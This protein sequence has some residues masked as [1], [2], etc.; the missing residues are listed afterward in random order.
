MNINT[1]FISKGFVKVPTVKVV[2]D[3]N[4]M[5]ENASYEQIFNDDAHYALMIQTELMRFGYILSPDAFNGVKLLMKQDQAQLATD[6]ANYFKNLYGDGQYTTLFGDYPNT[7]LSMEESEWMAKQILHYWTA[8]FK[9]FG[10]FDEDQHYNPN[11][12]DPNDSEHTGLSSM[13]VCCRDEYKVINAGSAD[14]LAEIIKV[15]V[16]SQQSLTDFDKDVV[17]TF[18]ENIDTIGLSPMKRVEMLDIN[19]PFKETLC[20]VS[21][22]CESFNIKDVTDVLRLANYLSGNDVELAPIPKTVDL[23]WSKRNL[24]VEEKKQYYFKHF[25]NKEKRI[26]MS[27]IEN[28]ANTKGMD[29]VLEDMKKY[30]GRWIRIGEI[31]HPCSEKNRK[32]YPHVSVLF[33]V[34]R[35]NPEGIVTWNS[36]VE[37]KKKERNCKELVDILSQRPGEFFRQIDYLVRTY[38]TEENYILT[39]LSKI[40]P[41]IK[42]KMCYELLDHFN[43]RTKKQDSRK[44]FIKGARKPVDLPVLNSLKKDTV[45][46][47]QA[48]VLNELCKRFKE[49]SEKN[50]GD[51]SNHKIYLSKDLEGIFLPKNMRS[52][53]NAAIQVARGTKMAIPEKCKCVRFFLHWK[54][55]D[56]RDDLDLSAAAYSEDFSKTIHIGWNTVWRVGTPDYNGYF[57]PANN[58]NGDVCVVFS[59]DVRNRR[60]NNAEY[61][62]VDIDAV[63]SMGYRYIV[64]NAH[65]YNSKSF[66][67]AYVGYMARTEFGTRGEITWAPNTVENC[68]KLGST[69][70]SVVLGVIDLLEKK[71]IYI[72]EDANGIPVSSVKNNVYQEMINRYSEDNFFNGLT[73]LKTYFTMSDIDD[74]NIIVLPEAEIKKMKTENEDAIKMIKNSIEHLGNRI[75]SYIK[76][77]GDSDNEELVLMKRDYAVQKNA[78]DAR[79]R[80]LFYTFDM[81]SNYASIMKFMFE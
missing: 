27:A 42:T 16:S 54:D 28:I 59:G 45:N 41:N 4:S 40:I 36:K 9:D 22:V 44:V 58:T 68:I 25:N 7:V 31:L 64:L 20:I 8:F 57:N 66:R 74:N 72:D 52:A 5:K 38:P 48:I 24:T 1:I 61:I 30:L 67:N 55:E 39:T 77:H 70:Q 81:M 69:T 6:I 32:K 21:S 2:S 63:H 10:I 35:N 49:S 60:G 29:F 56:G 33:N 46:S 65:D 73:L 47:I 50:F 19:V 17:K 37:A 14:D 13:S 11:P 62:D 78:L 75:E 76:E 43:V 23:G 53:N 79:E 34:L 51:L 80:T 3:N 26:L 12:N 18:Y 71:F 15:L